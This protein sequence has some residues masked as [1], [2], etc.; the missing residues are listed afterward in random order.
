MSSTP[1]KDWKALG[2]RLVRAGCRLEATATNHQRVYRGED[3][4]ATLQQS[5]SSSR[6]YQ[7]TIARIRRAGV[8]I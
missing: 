8:K 2:R 3:F 7:N 1:A 5:S 6:S 4:I